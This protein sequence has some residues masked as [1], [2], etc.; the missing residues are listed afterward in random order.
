FLQN[1]YRKIPGVS[2]AAQFKA[3]CACM[4]A[5][6]IPEA[7]QSEIWRLLSAVLHL[8]NITFKD[9]HDEET[10]SALNAQAA[11]VGDDSQTAAAVD[12]VCSLLGVDREV[13]QKALTN[14]TLQIGSDRSTAALQDVRQA[15]AARD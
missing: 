11:M 12:A 3:V 10:R 6:G 4:T 7:S 9:R 5:M 15:T 8:G 13:L 1:E 14:R 2:D